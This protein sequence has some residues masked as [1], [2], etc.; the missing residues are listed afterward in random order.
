MSPSKKDLADRIAKA[1]VLDED[2]LAVLLIG[3]VA[4]EIDSEDSDVDLAVFTQ[5][6]PGSAITTEV[7]EGTRVGIERFCTQGFP[8]APSTPLLHLQELRDAGRFVTGK[9]LYSRWER[10]PEVRQAWLDA[11][12]HPDEAAE[13]FGLA[14]TYLNLDRIRAC[15]SVPDRLWMIQGAVSA[16][17]TLA[18]SIGQVRFQ[19]PKWV[20]RDLTLEK[21]AELL[22][23]IRRFYFGKKVDAAF[24]QEVLGATKKELLAGLG[25]VGLPP[26]TIVENMYDR[27]PYV[28]R[29]FHDALSLERDGDFEG[30]VYTSLYSLRLL[31]ALLQ[32]QLALPRTLAV[33]EVAQWRHRAVTSVYPHIDAC[34]ED[35]ESSIQNLSE[36]GQRLQKLYHQRYSEA[37]N[38]VVARERW[39]VTTDR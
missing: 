35:L 2:V 34:L 33:A 36:G 29:T 6:I 13:L 37:E 8:A 30:C 18:L 3:S 16:L 21:Q 28:Y 10:L 7:V 32:D 22:K 31:N 38:L 17:A 9:V 14:A 25:L 12:L 23:G 5:S 27:Y 1:L 26:L 24:A 4:R 19:K 39:A 20:V 15:P 11:L